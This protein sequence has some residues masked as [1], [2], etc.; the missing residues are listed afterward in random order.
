[1]RSII[2]LIILL[3]MALPAQA[4]ERKYTITGTTAL[5]TAHSGNRNE[6]KDSHRG[7]LGTFTMQTGWERVRAGVLGVY[8]EGD[9]NV[10][11]AQGR[12]CSMWVVGG[13]VEYRIW[14]NDRFSI[15]A[16]AVPGWMNKPS[17][18]YNGP[19]IIPEASAWYDLGELGGFLVGGRVG[20]MSNGHCHV[21]IGALE[22][23]YTFNQLFFE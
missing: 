22:L 9:S 15:Y 19:I 21:G 7:I 5:Q 10:P 2:L 13:L 23:G 11:S 20:A 1:M 3:T 16:G 14:S 12:D 17:N 18:N 4:E 8:L 6:V